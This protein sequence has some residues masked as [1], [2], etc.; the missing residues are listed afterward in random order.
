MT[1]SAQDQLCFRKS[2]VYLSKQLISQKRQCNPAASGDDELMTG[3]LKL[4]ARYG[5]L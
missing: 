4:P 5:P 3:F 2:L 1:P